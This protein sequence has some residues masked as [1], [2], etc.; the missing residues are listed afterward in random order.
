MSTDSEIAPVRLLDRKKILFFFSLALCAVGALAYFLFDPT[1]VAIFPPCLFHEMTGLDC[2]GCGAQ[3]ALHQL[4]HGNIIAALRLNAMFVLS[5]P[6]WALYGPRFLLR[7]FKGEP[8]GL[9]SR[10]LWCYLAAWLVFGFLR[11]LPVPLFA[12]FAA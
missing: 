1:K 10:W 3:R 2:P 11:N 12:W 6:V 5:L 4:L 9:K 7:A 8:T